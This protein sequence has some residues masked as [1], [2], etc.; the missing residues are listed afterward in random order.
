MMAPWPVISRGTECT[1][2]MAPGLVSEI[3]TPAKSSA[4]SFA[5]PGPADDVLVGGDELREA[6]VSQRLIPATTNER[7]LFLPCRSIASP[8]LVC[9]G[10]TAAGLPSTSAWRR[11]H[12]QEL[13]D[14]LHHREA[15]QVLAMLESAELAGSDGRFA[16][17][18][19]VR[20]EE[21]GGRRGESGL[22]TSVSVSFR[23]VRGMSEGIVKLSNQTRI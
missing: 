22:A 9:A 11:F 8:R 16:S 19:S 14:R 23:K 20:T 21:T 6:Q 17:P 15:D 5:V 10:V 7:L 3:V 12:V 4:V 18:P 1:V 2:P 13:F